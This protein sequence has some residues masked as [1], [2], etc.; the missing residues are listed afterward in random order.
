MGDNSKSE[1]S[2]VKWHAA[3]PARKATERQN[4]LRSVRQL[5]DSSFA[6]ADARGE[7]VH[8]RKRLLCELLSELP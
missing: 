5:L 6:G 1:L 8:L 2:M 7:G 3:S 4:Q